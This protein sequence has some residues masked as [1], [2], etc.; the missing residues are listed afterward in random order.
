MT[1]IS[2][3][4]AGELLETVGALLG[5]FLINETQYPS[6]GGQMRYNG[7]DFQTLH[8]VQIEPG[9]R[10]SELARKMGIAPTTQQSALDR[11]IRK[12]LIERYDHPHAKNGK[13][14]RLTE[15]GQALRMAITNQDMINM[16]AILSTLEPEERKDA[17]RILAK[18]SK[19]LGL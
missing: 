1:E 17:V 11:L 8:F 4:Q 2:D 12:G 5:L 15:A 6:A 18:V 7:I 13:A 19:G 16:K 9:I 14:H 10:G 3:Q